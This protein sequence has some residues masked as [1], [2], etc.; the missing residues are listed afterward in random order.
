MYIDSIPSNT[1]LSQKTCERFFTQLNLL[2]M[3]IIIFHVIYFDPLLHI[4]FFYSLGTFYLFL[5]NMS[6][7]L[8]LSANLSIYL[9]IY[10]N[11]FYSDV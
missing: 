5:F 4:S 11:C 9:S 7:I 2:Y 8:H 6:F 3:Y 10:L 1:L